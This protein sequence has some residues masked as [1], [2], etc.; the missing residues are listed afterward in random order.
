MKTL[1][2]T[3]IFVLRV[4]ISAMML[5]HGWPKLIKWIAGLAEPSA[6]NFMDFMG[7][8]PFV[9]L[10]LCVVGEF[11]APIAIIVGWKTKWFA[12]VA[13]FTM[14][15]AAFVAHAGDSYGDRE[16]ALLFLLPFLVLVL[17]GA[18]RWSLDQRH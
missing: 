12:S 2:D 15:V 7:M 16:H 13:A 5:T 17:T 18:G 4:G 14:F 9:S 10:S 8:G 11:V 1:S 6:V 3:G